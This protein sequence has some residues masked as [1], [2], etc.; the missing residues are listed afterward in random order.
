MAYVSPGGGGNYHTSADY[1]G[2]ICAA[3]KKNPT[4]NLTILKKQIENDTGILVNESDIKSVVP[5]CEQPIVACK[6]YVCYWWI[7]LAFVLLFTLIFFYWRKRKKGE[8]VIVEEY[9]EDSD[10]ED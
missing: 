9:S 6:W 5:T 1:G 7:I 4:N 10:E 2:I 8:K 3:Y